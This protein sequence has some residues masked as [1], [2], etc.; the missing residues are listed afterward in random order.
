MSPKPRALD[1]AGAGSTTPIKWNTP[2][3]R[4]FANDSSVPGVSASQFQ[5]EVAQAFSAWEGVPDA[6][7][8]FQFVG[9]TSAAPFEDD[10]L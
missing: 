9:F 8:A 6:S 3:V 7:V 4:W 5:A 2:R 10:G 1:R